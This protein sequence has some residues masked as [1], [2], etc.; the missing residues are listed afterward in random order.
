MGSAGLRGKQERKTSAKH[1][2]Q[3]APPAGST[4]ETNPSPST[5]KTNEKGGGRSEDSGCEDDEEGG[6]ERRRVHQA[7]NQ[8]TGGSRTAGSSDEDRSL[9]SKS[10][11]LC[12]STVA[13]HH[14]GPQAPSSVAAGAPLML[15]FHMPLLFLPVLCWRRYDHGSG[16]PI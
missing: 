3:K 1:Q 16:T 13:G 6:E 15:S 9:A 10:T 14:R 4:D 8:L 2:L 7:Q 11:A 5:K 12:A